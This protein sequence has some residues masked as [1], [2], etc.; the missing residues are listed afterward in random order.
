AAGSVCFTVAVAAV[1]D[2][3]ELVALLPRT[4]GGG[5]LLLLSYAGLT[6]AASLALRTAVAVTTI[7]LVIAALPQVLMLRYVMS[8]TWP[9]VWKILV[10]YA[11]PA[12]A[13]PGTLG[14]VLH[15][16][17]DGTVMIGVAMLVAARRAGRTT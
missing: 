1:S 13:I 17:G 4:L 12:L 11:A 3:M 10:S 16:V 5:L 2:S 9:P 8:E 7:V 6:V 15:A 14:D